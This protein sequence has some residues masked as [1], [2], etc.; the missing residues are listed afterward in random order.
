MRVVLA[1]PQQF[2]I[3]YLSQFII[4]SSAHGPFSFSVNVYV[5]NIGTRESL[6]RKSSTK[7]LYWNRETVKKVAISLGPK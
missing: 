1:T 4:I 3:S 7:H 2:N 5:K 6:L